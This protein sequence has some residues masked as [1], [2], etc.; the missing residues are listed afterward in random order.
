MRYLLLSILFLSAVSLASAEKDGLYTWWQMRN[1]FHGGGDLKRQVKFKDW[2]SIIP[3]PGDNKAHSVGHSICYCDLKEDIFVMEFGNVDPWINWELVARPLENKSKWKSIAKGTG[4]EISGKTYRMP[5]SK[6]GYPRWAGADM[7]L[8]LKAEKPGTV[9]IM[10]WAVLCDTPNPYAKQQAMASKALAR[11]N[12]LERGMIPHWNPKI[13][14]FVCAYNPTHPEH[15]NYWLEDEGEMLWSLGN[16]PKMMELYGKG[17]RDFIVKHTKFGAPVRK[18][19]TQPLTGEMRPIGGKFV[20][21]TGILLVDGNLSENPNIKLHHS[22]YEMHALLAKLGDFFV[23]YETD[24]GSKGKITF[25]KP[26]I[27]R[28]EPDKPERDHVQF[29][30]ESGDRMASAKF[31]TVIYR[32]R[33]SVYAEVKNKGQQP[34]QNVTAGFDLQDCNHY[35]KKAL[36]KHLQFG[37]VAILYADQPLLEECNIV[38]LAGPAAKNINPQLDKDNNIERVT[39]AAPISKK[40]ATGAETSLKLV[41]LNAG[42]ISFADKIE[43]YKDV[44][45]EDA[46]IS[47]SYVNTYA[48]L[49]LSV[50]S[51]RYPQDNE[52]REVTNRMIENFLKARDRMRDRELGYLLWVLDLFGREKDAN[53][54]ADLI[55]KRVEP[56]EE[57]TPLDSAAM[58]MGLR[59]AGRWAVADKVETK[60]KAEWII[61]VAPPTE[62]LGLGALQTPVTEEKAYQQLTNTLRTMV[63]DEPDK[64]TTHNDYTVPEG[65]QETQC[66]TLVAFDLFSRLYGGIIPFKVDPFKNSEITKISFD[67]KTGEWKMAMKTAGDCDIFTHF[68]APKQVLWNGKPLGSDNMKYDPNTGVVFLTNLDGDGEI[69]LTVEGPAPKDDPAW[70]PIDYIGLDKKN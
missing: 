69:A 35:Y 1:M 24:D 48:L 15:Y 31:T 53:E 13:G 4:E 17:L 40:L 51:Y 29:V 41:H 46:D 54:I 12:P 8:N 7:L 67:E 43:I 68:R 38:R 21:D 37:D 64:A 9:E 36:N 11:A 60:V 3:V 50:Y 20:F 56:Q 52:A 34:L 26:K 22:V 70:P 65:P 47:M 25:D 6:L 18:V 14:G 44:D 42:S 2:K 58:E 59:R 55:E 5:L 57:I 16:Y 66:Y 62:L 61:G 30:I 45:F 19:N 27:Y 23:S 49:G 33:A 63:W 32:G 28:I 39:V 10:R